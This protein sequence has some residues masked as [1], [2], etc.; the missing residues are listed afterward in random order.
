MHPARVVHLAGLHPRAVSCQDA[1]QFRN[2]H[3]GIARGG[4]WKANTVRQVLLRQQHR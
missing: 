4:N 2:R 1:P 3:P